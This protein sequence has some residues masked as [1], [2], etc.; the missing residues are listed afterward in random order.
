MFKWQFIWKKKNIHIVI[1]DDSTVKDERRSRF[2]SNSP[3]SVDSRFSSVWRVSASLD[4]S[5]HLPCFAWYTV[6][7]ITSLD[8]GILIYVT[9]DRPPPPHHPFPTHRSPF[10]RLGFHTP[11]FL[12]APL[13]KSERK[14][15][16]RFECVFIRVIF[17]FWKSIGRKRSGSPSSLTPSRSAQDTRY[18][19]HM[20]PPSLVSYHCK[21]SGGG[22]AS[23]R[24]DS[25][26][27]SL[28]STRFRNFL[29][30]GSIRSDNLSR[31]LDASRLC[32]LQL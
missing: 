9:I 19:L 31:N 30:R 25:L 6:E 22:W 4:T 2:I 24:R 17:Q 23:I 5:V 32:L 16:H 21:R 18:K 7:V 15:S 12:P 10:F 1:D 8:I 11:N 20:L 14:R 26:V 28:F 27:E 3:S 13:R 29:L